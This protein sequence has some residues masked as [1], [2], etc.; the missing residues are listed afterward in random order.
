M[1]QKIS[2]LCGSAFTVD[3]DEECDLDKNPELYRQIMNGTFLNFTCSECGKKHKPEFPLIVLWP[4][5]KLRI[6]VLPELERGEFIRRKKDPPHTETIIGYP[7]LADRLAVIRDG[8]EP[9]AIEALKYFLLVRAEESYPD[10]RISAWYHCIK[11]DSE[12]NGEYIEFHLHGIK[13]DEVAISKIPWRLYEK[14]LADFRKKPKSELFTSL[15]LRTY[16]S[17]ANMIRP[18]IYGVDK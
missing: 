14:N 10:L 7:E 16:L 15:R 11:S 17:V 8:L 6:E 9:V 12:G 4:Q 1:K 5:K 2:C 18:D 13:A 3:V